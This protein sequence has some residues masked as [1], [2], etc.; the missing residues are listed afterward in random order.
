MLIAFG[1]IA[2][3]FGVGRP[4]PSALGA[5]GT[6]GRVRVCLSKSRGQVLWAFGFA[7]LGVLRRSTSS[8]A[9][10]GPPATGGSPRQTPC[11]PWNFSGNGWQLVATVFACFCVFRD[12]SICRRLPPF[13]TTGLHKGS[14]HGTALERTHPQLNACLRLITAMNL[15]PFGVRRVRG[16]REWE[17]RGHPP[18]PR[19][20]AASIEF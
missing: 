5:C 16:S 14:I 13:A 18:R 20:N 2:R 10:R 17:R 6:S 4:P 11:L 8:F 15:C 9:G 1:N 19:V 12:S 7:G 3:R